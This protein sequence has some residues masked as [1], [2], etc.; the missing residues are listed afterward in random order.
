MKIKVNNY[1]KITWKCTID[2]LKMKSTMKQYLYVNLNR[3]KLYIFF[4]ITISLYFSVWLALKQT[5][6]TNIE[7]IMASHK[8]PA[9]KNPRSIR[10]ENRAH[11]HINCL[12][13]FVEP[14]TDLFHKKNHGC[15]ISLNEWT[16][17][18]MGPIVTRET[19]TI[20]KNQPNK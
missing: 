10:I 2:Y 4:I 18:C 19:Q 9:K 7:S 12:C 5:N 16:N 15:F 6:E 3:S 8:F 1:N 20:N 17:E 11:I 14:D 13:V